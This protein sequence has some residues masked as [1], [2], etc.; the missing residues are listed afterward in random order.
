VPSYGRFDL[1]FECGDGNYFWE[2]NGERYLDF[3]GGIAG[4]T[5]GFANREIAEALN[6]QSRKLIHISN[7]H[8]HELQGQLAKRIADLI[9]AGR[10]FLQQRVTN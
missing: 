3:A 1:V 5:L 9:G 2:V 4:C 10:C 8:C 6:A 7:L